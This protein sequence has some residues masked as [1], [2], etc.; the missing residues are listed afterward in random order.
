MNKRMDFTVFSIGIYTG[1]ICEISPY[2]GGVY[3]LFFAIYIVQAFGVDGNGY[4]GEDGRGRYEARG[5][6][7]IL[8]AR[9]D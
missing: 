1:Y 9:G 5:M 3:S 4:E 6:G 8:S 7:E 2:S